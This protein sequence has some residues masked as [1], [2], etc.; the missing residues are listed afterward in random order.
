MA[1]A[2]RKLRP[3]C[4]AIDSRNYRAAVKLAAN[5]LKKHPDLTQAHALRALALVRAGSAA[6]GLAAADAVAQGRPADEWVLSTLLAAYRSAGVPERATQLFVDAAAARPDCEELAVAAFQCHVREDSYALMQQAASNLHQR[7]R[8]NK[9]YFLRVACLLCQA[10]AEPAAT[11]KLAGLCEILMKKALDEHRLTQRSEAEL[12][13]EIL[14]VVGKHAAIAEL[15]ADGGRLA[16]LYEQQARLE[17]RAEALHKAGDHAAARAAFADLLLRKESRL[18]WLFFKGYLEA[19]E[20]AAAATGEAAAGP[21]L[22]AVDLE[23]RA[24]SPAPVVLGRMETYVSRYVQK[25]TCA[26]DMRPYMAHVL[27][28][29]ATPREVQQALSQSPGTSARA[30]EFFVRLSVFHHQLRRML[31]FH[32]EL[33]P[34]QARSAFGEVVEEYEKAVAAFPHKSSKTPNNADDLLLIA[35]SL[36]VDAYKQ[37][38]DASAL[39]ADAAAL[40]AGI[41]RSENNLQIRM[42]LVEVYRELEASR[43]VMAHFTDKNLGVKHV[44]VET[45]APLVLDALLRLCDWGAAYD[46][47]NTVAAV[48]GEHRAQVPEFMLQCLPGEGSSPAQQ[49][50]YVKFVEMDGFRR[51]MRC[52]ALLAASRTENVLMHLLYSRPDAPAQ[53]LTAF[54]STFEAATIRVGDG[55]LGALE[56]HADTSVP[57]WRLWDAVVDD[58]RGPVS[59]SLEPADAPETA[60]SLAIF[61]DVGAQSGLIKLR[62]IAIRALACSAR[63]EAEALAE[64]LPALAAA[65]KEHGPKAAGSY[66]SLWQAFVELV[67]LD[68]ECLAGRAGSDEFRRSGAAATAALEAAARAL[69]TR[70]LYELS[71]VAL[72]LA[73]CAI[74]VASASASVRAQRKKATR[75]AKGQPAPAAPEHV[76]VA[77]AGVNAAVAALLAVS[78]EL[79]VRLESRPIGVQTPQDSSP[80]DLVVKAAVEGSQRDSVRALLGAIARIDAEL[81][82]ASL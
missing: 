66:A 33:R 62:R 14:E 38:R 61:R 67:A 22:A 71:P 63:H 65:H 31:G 7:F 6:E 43:G 57:L 39:V 4:D 41:A 13:V 76:Q 1:D 51:R 68:A 52:S 50:N 47:M 28:L 26:A 3:I 27:S 78:K 37:T 36:A 69:E 17:L 20:R 25:P 56:S 55:E 12:Y 32:K 9:Y 77:V 16:P 49:S 23:K 70:S 10:K 75:A 72:V 29:G 73:M 48:H 81:G 15:F 79:R 34:E 30:S 2:T 59:S 18:N 45:L 74:V 42:A 21:W 53:S 80:A 58:G 11:Q 24:G 19:T 35:H 82:P 40:E 64:E 46:L 54:V 5:V 44:M 8:D 60:S